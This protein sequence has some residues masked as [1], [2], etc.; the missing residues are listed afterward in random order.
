M[1]SV[2]GV[3]YDGGGTFICRRGYA[4]VIYE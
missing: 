1:D 2:F 3:A 4:V